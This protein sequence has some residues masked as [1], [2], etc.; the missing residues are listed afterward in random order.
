V[1]VVI[2]Q[3]SAGLDAAANRDAVRTLG[4]R[5]AASAPDLLVLPEAAMHD[6]GPAA[7]SLAAVAE[8]LDGPFAATVGEVAR[9]LGAHVVAGMFEASDAAGTNPYNT[10]LVVAP[11]GT[12]RASYRKLHLYDAYAYRESDRLTAGAVEPPTVE[13]GDLTIGLSTCYDLRFPEIALSL[14]LR[15]AAALV[16]P[17]AWVRGPGKESHWTTLLTARAIENSMYALGAAQCGPHYCGS[18]MAIGPT[19]EVLGR[20]GGDPG[21]LPVELMVESV[22]AARQT[23][24]S[25]HNRRYGDPVLAGGRVS[26]SDR[27]TESP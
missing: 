25:L 4:Q 21:V 24:P 15:G 14:A 6:F 9:S 20:L 2:G 23:N 11:D 1:Q 8:P 12:L 17:A 22:A 27:D 19:G 3:F 16:V 5:A 10:L 26:P 18:S 7:M 13:V